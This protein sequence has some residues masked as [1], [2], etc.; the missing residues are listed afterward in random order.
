MSHHDSSTSTSL[1]DPVELFQQVL[2]LVLSTGELVFIFMKMTNAGEW[3]FV[4]S[5]VPIYSGKLVDPGFHMTITH[6][7]G[8]LALACSEN[9]FMV[10]ELEPIEEL[11]KRHS[12]GKPIEPI[13]SKWVRAVKG[14]IH[15]LQFLYPG[16]ENMA[17]VVLL[18]IT[19][20]SGIFR[21]AICQWHN[22]EHLE[23]AF[24]EKKSGHR[25]DITTNGLPL[26]IIPL[27]VRCQF[28]AIT[29]KSIGIWSDVL[30]DSPRFTP[31]ELAPRGETAWHHGSHN[32]MWTAWARPLREEPYHADT[33][34]I[35]LAREDGWL[36][37]LEISGEFGL[38]SGVYMGPLE[39]N[40]DSAFASLSTTTGELLVASGD[41][42]PGAIWSVQPRRKP[43]RI[44]LLPNWSPTVD[45]A[46]VKQTSAHTKLDQSKIP[47]EPRL[48]RTQT[49]SLPPE[50]I[51][52]CSGRD[53]SGALVELRHGIQAKIGLDIDYSSPIQK[54]WAIP[55]LEG[56]PEAGFFMLLALPEQSALLHISH[57]LSE[58][59]EKDRNTEKEFDLSSTTLAVYVSRDVVIQITAAH[60]T[61]VTSS[62]WCRHSI[63]DLIEDPRA[64][65]ADSAITNEILALSVYSRAAF[66]ILV[67]RVDGAEFSLSHCFKVDGDVTALCISPSPTGAS[68]LAGISQ[69]DSSTLAIFPVD[70]PSSDSQ[71]G[72][73]K[74]RLGEGE[75]VM[76]TPINAVTSI[77]C[78]NKESIVVGL[79]NG[80]VLTIRSMNIGQSG[81]N[82]AITSTNSFGVSP[83]RVFAGTVSNTGSSILVCNDAG[84]A[85]ANESRS[86][87]FKEIFR[88]W[89]TDANEPQAV[90]PT[91]DSVT[92]LCE[93]PNYNDSTW[94]MVSGAQI[95]I[96]ELQ[97]HPAAIPRYMPIAG[98]P[99][100]VL[101]SERLKALVTV[102]VKGGVPSLHFIDPAT[103]TDL[104]HPMRKASD[105]DEAALADYISNLG[106]PDLKVSS[107]LNWR[108]ES[109]G[110]LYEWFVIL[111]R[112]GDNHGRLLVVSA[113]PE[114]VMDN[115][116]PHRRIRFWTQFYRKFKD[117]QPRC[118]TTD[119][120][121][122]FLSLGRTVEYHVI[123][124]KKFRVA[125]K[126][127]LPSPAMCLE[128]AGGR[129]HALTS[130][131]SLVILDYTSDAA[132]KSQRMVQVCTDEVARN[133][134]HSIDLGSAIGLEEGQ[135]FV[136]MSDLMCGVYG[137][138]S[139]GRD[140][141]GHN[142]ELIFRANLAM[143]VRRFV[144][145]R[146]RPRWA[147]GQ[148]LHRNIPS[149][150]NEPD[151]LG[152]A[153][154][155]SL[156]Q[157]TIINEH[158][159]QVFRYI[160]DLVV[161]SG[162]VYDNPRGDNRTNNLHLEP[163]SINKAKTHIDGDILQRCLEV[164][165]LERIV[166]GPHPKLQE[167]LLTLHLGTGSTDVPDFNEAPPRHE[168]LYGLL[169]YYLSPAL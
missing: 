75:D 105:Q 107:L 25:L 110:N 114:V 47:K 140:F 19:A 90:S 97:P 72:P 100:G 71:T 18:L 78:P 4:A 8:Y 98:T 108:Y 38:D 53:Q 150:L 89:L 80:D 139:P 132:I 66:K 34:L 69:K 41:C 128:V 49:H 84:L 6:D 46:L 103:G 149:P 26:L 91:I 23:R 113:E 102:V 158:V 117:E 32:P 157:I 109:K 151:I 64:K 74:V 50:R 79:R 156:T 62:G 22:G 28:L 137:L 88:V 31:I 81:R 55:N 104:S 159:W 164:K 27:T 121:G 30:I 29:E 13:R 130:N 85:I 68:V 36:N 111:A 101:Y 94:A 129:L 40:I 54:C 93:I 37:C 131:H 14:A 169:E 162:E 120:D 145:G 70:P 154:D 119:A 17:R 11:R 51:F 112:S 146:T 12:E 39:C 87:Y 83:S 1:P 82:Y 44:G 133:G 116:I 153:I 42:S 77:I 76:S 96:T 24:G 123:E 20:Q 165:A 43:E 147:R 118:G 59:S 115:N 134:L 167:M 127:D 45:L 2:V 57:D 86:G 3:E 67:F 125:M 60:A 136:L 166:S 33:D 48:E 163:G 5:H 161:E 143:S 168:F 148:P 95:L 135:R 138:W 21:Q 92:S 35:Y 7:G 122:L 65:V 152:L 142:L 61:V 16:S 99:L 10:Y 144:R 58:V 15:K 63:S 73:I 52:A 160:Q 124:D 126:C 106:N 155:G 141:D 9:M 56:T